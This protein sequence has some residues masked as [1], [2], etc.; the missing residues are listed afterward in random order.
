MLNETFSV[1]F[2]HRDAGTLAKLSDAWLFWYYDDSP[3]LKYGVKVNS[4]KSLDYFMVTE[5][6][7]SRTFGLK[8]RRSSIL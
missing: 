6:E 3:V 1:I 2:K 7:N 8:N 5:H 4:R